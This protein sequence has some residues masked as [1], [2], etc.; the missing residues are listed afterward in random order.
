MIPLPADKRK[1]ICKAILGSWLSNSAK[2]CF[3]VVIGIFA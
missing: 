3:L 1:A 2:V